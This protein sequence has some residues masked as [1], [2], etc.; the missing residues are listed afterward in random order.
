MAFHKA[1]TKR[2]C[3]F[4]SAPL[5]W[6]PAGYS[7]IYSR[8][9]VL[10]YTP[11]SYLHKSFIA[12]SFTALSVATLHSVQC[13]RDGRIMNL[14]GF[15]WFSRYSDG[16]R[17]GRPGFD[18]RHRFFCTP[19]RPGRLWSPPILLSNGYRGAF[20]GL[21]RPGREADHSPPSSAEVKSGAAIPQFL[22]TS[23]WR[24]L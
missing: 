13:S 22:Y 15:G 9:A 4:F 21:K 8:E 18:S 16:L 6:Q 5:S 17:A 20:P 7:E 2:A 10:N 23:S 1:F 12:N 19:R 11:Q 24:D 3:F 14:N